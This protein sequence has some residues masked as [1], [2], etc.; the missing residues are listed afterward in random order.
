[1]EESPLLAIQS[2]KVQFEILPKNVNNVHLMTNKIH[3][4]P[5]PMGE[6]NVQ[7]GPMPGGEN[8]VHPGPIRT[9]DK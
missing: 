3:P 6:K 5:I 2:S 1:M 7:P 8:N 9:G 4:G